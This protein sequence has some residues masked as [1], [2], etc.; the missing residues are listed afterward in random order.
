ME[1]ATGNMAA[2]DSN[3]SSGSSRQELKALWNASHLLT[4]GLVNRFFRNYSRYRDQSWQ[5]ADREQLISTCYELE[6]KIYAYENLQS[7]YTG[8]SI[9]EADLQTSSLVLRQQI[10]DYYEYLHHQLLYRDPDTIDSIIPL[11]DQQLTL[12]RYENAHTSL[13][14]LELLEATQTLS[15]IEMLIQDEL[16]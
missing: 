11:I 7:T 16:S 1:S 10:Y 4:L 13:S 8:S 9:S 5:Y 6:H 2:V 3:N 15:H 12:W 14:S